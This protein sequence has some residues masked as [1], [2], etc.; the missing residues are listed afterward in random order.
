[1]ADAASNGAQKA[2]ALLLGLGPEVAASIFRLLGESE[3]RKIA[4]LGAWPGPAAQ[5]LSQSG[6]RGH[7]LDR[8]SVV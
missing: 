1:M 7:T 5:A 2:A 4:A 8:K 3:V 6:S